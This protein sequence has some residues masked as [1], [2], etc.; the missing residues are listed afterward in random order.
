[1]R[2]CAIRHLAGA[3]SI[4]GATFENQFAYTRTSLIMSIS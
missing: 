4:P 1:M 2:L 3:E